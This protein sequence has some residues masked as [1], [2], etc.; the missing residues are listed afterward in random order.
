MFDD[1]QETEEIFAALLLPISTLHG[2]CFYALCLKCFSGC[3]ACLYH[4]QQL[5]SREK[6]KAGIVL[7]PFTK[8]I[9]SNG[10]A[11]SDEKFL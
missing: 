5:G 11:E 7:W 1:P 10:H 2:S 4:L 6:G 3:S 9:H 8:T